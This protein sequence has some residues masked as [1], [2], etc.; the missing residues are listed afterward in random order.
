MSPKQSTMPG[1]QQQLLGCLPDKGVILC[2]GTSSPPEQW[3]GRGT[4]ST[5][6]PHSWPWP[7]DDSRRCHGKVW[8]PTTGTHFRVILQRTLCGHDGP[9][10]LCPKKVPRLP[11]ELQRP[12]GP[13]APSGVQSPSPP[14]S[15]PSCS[16]R[17]LHRCPKSSRITTCFGTQSTSPVR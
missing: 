12:E 1:K 8:H 3:L 5:A 10:K 16:H 9:L 4:Q 6:L 11:L 17:L 14:C 7:A 2:F 15:S 13:R